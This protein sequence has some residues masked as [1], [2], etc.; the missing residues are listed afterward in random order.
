[1]G[2]LA[3]ALTDACNTVGTFYKE[4]KE[5]FGSRPKEIGM[6][7]IFVLT[8]YKSSG[9]HLKA[10]STSPVSFSLPQ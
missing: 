9:K 5:A 2:D 1:M 10:V 4:F 6:T 7:D 8:A 3:T